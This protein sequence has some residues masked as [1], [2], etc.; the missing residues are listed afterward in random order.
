MDARH[1]SGAEDR[2]QKVALKERLGA[3]VS[4]EF[5]LGRNRA[6]QPPPALRGVMLGAR[7][8]HAVQ[9]RVTGAHCLHV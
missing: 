9:A 2:L 3:E 7:R 5:V 8:S 1:F 6:G 4:Q